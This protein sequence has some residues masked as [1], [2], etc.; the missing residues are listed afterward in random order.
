VSE[1]DP[2]AVLRRLL[3]TARELTGARYA[4]IGV[5]DA[6]RQNL[7]RF[8]VAGIGD[9]VHSVIGDLPRG[10]GVLGVLIDDPQPLR[11][12]DVGRH[13][14]SYGFPPGH[15]PMKTFLGVPILIHGEAWGNLYLTEKPEDFTDGDEKAVV[16]LAAWAGIAIANARSYKAERE[17]RAEMERVNQALETT[18]EVARALG[19]ITDVDRVLELIA[20]RS[21]A[22]V[23]ARA[24]GIGLIEGGELV[25][26]AVAGQD[27]APFL[28][29]RTP[30]ESSLAAPALRAGRA[31]HLT[32]MP[33]GSVAR[34]H[35]DTRQAIVTPMIFKGRPLGVLTVLD[36][37]EGDEKFTPEHVRLLEA[38]AASAATAVATAQRATDEALR[39]SLAASELERGRWA[40]ELHDETLQ[41]LAGLRVLI[42]AARRSEDP[43]RWRAAMDDAVE[44]IGGAI[45]SLRALITD[46]RPASLDELGLEA[47]LEALAKRTEQRNGVPVDLSYDLHLDDEGSG[48]RLASEL[49]AGVY[50][51]V[52]EAITNAVKHADANAITVTIHGSDES[53]EIEVVDT[54]KGFDP[55]SADLGFGLLGMR[56]RAAVLEG[57]LEISSRP[58]D[59]TTVTARIPLRRLPAERDRAATG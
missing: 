54:G 20:K 47:A 10:R 41:E 43:K 19:G 23:G 28:G 53:V 58:G 35:L 4:A 12:H 48:P 14:L 57:A 40:R 46:L 56:E 55:E 31:M 15:P 34:D 8:I 11:L 17:R 52:Q 26:V 50:R 13:P 37:I 45:H 36:R 39:R 51:L 5:L 25:T 44:L 42:S 21:R 32:D 1:L 3:D 22:L 38:F 6:D 18:T 33:E 59:G 24:A 7:E 49:E 27:I 2:D 30:I 29:V 16:V 9:E